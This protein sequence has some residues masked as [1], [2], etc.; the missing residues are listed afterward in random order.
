M[1]RLVHPP[2]TL[3]NRNRIT[4]KYRLKI[5]HGNIDTDPF[6]PDEDDEKSRSSLA[7]AGVDQEDANVS[8]SLPITA[9]HVTHKWSRVVAMCSAEHHLQAVLSEA[10]QRNYAPQQRPSRGANDKKAAPPA[11]YIPTPD[12]TGK[13]ENYE[14]LYP[15]NK[16]KDPVTYVCTSTTVEEAISYALAH[17]CTY[18]MDERDKEWLDKNNEE[19]RGEGTSVQGAVST[20]SGVRTSA[21]SAKAKGKEPESSTPVVIS[22]DEFELAMGLFEKV[23]HEKTEHLHL[24]LGG[25][26]FPSFADYQDTFS[27]PLVPSDFAAFAVPSW[28]PPPSTLLRIGRAVYPHWK[29]RR[30]EREGHR[31]IPTLNGDESD[32]LN[33]SYICFRRR[34]IKA[35]RKTRASQVTS[36]DKLL[37]LQGEFAY[38][39]D[40]A[41][42]V[43]AR[44]GLKQ[45]SARQAQN[46]W[47][48]RMAVVDLKRKF[49]S[50]GDRTD[51]ELLIDKERP[52]KK[53]EMSR[54][55]GLKIRTPNDPS[56]AMASARVEPA[57]KPQAR[58]AMIQSKIDIELTRQ[59]DH[60]WEDGIN[61]TYQQPVVPYASRLFKYVPP[62]G[63]PSWPSSASS[64][65]DDE[66]VV[67]RAVRVRVGRGGRIMLDRR[68]ATTTSVSI[69]KQSR[70]SLFGPPPDD[71]GNDE[72][73]VEDMN[74]LKERWRFDSDDY[75]AVG[76]DGPEEQDR[77]LTDEY[78]PKYL[79]H[80]MCLLSENDHQGLTTDTSLLFSSTDGSRDPTKVPGFRLGMQFIMTRRDA[81]GQPRPFPP[82]G[83]PPMISQQP[84]GPTA[85]LA[86]VNGTPISTQMKKMQPMPPAAGQH[87][88]RISSNGGMRPPN[89][90]VVASMQSHTSPPR[91][92]PPHPPLQQHSPTPPGSNG[93]INMPHL[94]QSNPEAAGAHGL[95]VANGIVSGHQPSEPT[96]LLQP[97]ENMSNGVM[98][99]NSPV[100]PKSVNQHAPGTN[101][102]QMPNM[103]GGMNGYLPSGLPSNAAYLPPSSSSLSVQQKQLLQAA[104]SNPP[105][106]LQDLQGMQPNGGN[107]QMPG[108][109]GYMLPNGAMF[110]MALGTGTNIN[111][112]LPPARQMNW[113]SPMR[114]NSAMNGMEGAAMN[115]GMNGGMNG[116]MN[117]AM[118]GSSL[119]GA[120]NGPLINGAI[121]SMNGS[122]NGAMNGS[123][124]PSPNH[125]HAVP[126][127]VRTPSANGSRNGIRA[128]NGQ[129]NG[130]L[131]S[132]SMSPH[133]QHSPS[134]MPSISQSQSP[135]RPPMTPMQMGEHNV[136]PRVFDEALYVM[137]HLPLLPGYGPGSN[138]RSSLPAKTITG[139]SIL[140]RLS[141][142]EEDGYQGSYFPAAHSPKDRHDGYIS[143][144]SPVFARKSYPGHEGPFSHESVPET[145]AS[146][147][148]ETPVSEPEPLP[149]EP[150]TPTNPQP[151]APTPEEEVAEVIFFEYGVVVFF[152]LDEQQEKS[153]LEDVENAGIM[154]KKIS[155]EDWEIEECHFA[156]DRHIAYPR[157]YNDFF[158]LKSRSHLL[159]LSIAHALAQSTLLAHYETNTQRV[160]SS[161]LTLS[162][163]KQL[164]TSGALQLRRHDAL[165]LTGSLFKLRRDVNLVSNVLDVPELFWSEASLK[166]LYDAVREYMEIKGRVQV[167]NEKLA[168][169]SDFLDAIHDHLNNFA[170]ERIT[171]IIIWQVL[172]RMGSWRVLTHPLRL[173]VAAILVELGEVV[174][175]LIVHATMGGD[176][177]D[178]VLS[179]ESVLMTLERMML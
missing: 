90:P 169:A 119:T 153:I 67:Q 45:E 58:A 81:S 71:D 108:P 41:K 30:V 8:L 5:I 91:A 4:N 144:E 16:W 92:S 70:S 63:A 2:T 77:V 115:G 28:I 43:L 14:Q 37:R 46:V 25:M 82:G 39:L 163:P 6:I 145:P 47:E 54:L 40:L 106:Q 20:A 117:G 142:A 152:G 135:P 125:R 62:S 103:N 44:E 116:A 98:R 51:D 175:R 56:T 165:K 151:A 13:V 150:P 146:E 15:S 121:G 147:V 68:R 156:H 127:P 84:N 102:Y 168:V 172:S 104:F 132:H 1:P 19:A 49:P 76:P 139:K 161:P 110:N 160:L 60:H 138:I 130:Q 136:A 124:S 157:I 171:W 177:A 86:P 173:I 114:P 10:A 38:P 85:P 29:E 167:L 89:V 105:N 140:S 55:P 17:E 170:M 122:M 123:M 158:T 34:E 80:S 75:P 27:S 64:T 69:V 134:P 79:R 88:P 100:R 131:N 109:G 129:M 137:Y 24:S 154:K 36:S 32:V 149:G 112:K 78:D 113:A 74:R 52:P 35:V 3:R 164:A 176:S 99:A 61:N 94:G 48:K 118:N 31:I 178:P 12:S 107:R 26:P 95:P 18:Y 155:E 141:E 9:G 126:V 11:A 83:Q 96:N 22:E 133:M 179:R 111:L 101:G 23:T 159:K 50:L 162:I 97:P 73:D 59:K 42:A 57:M 93:Q 143:S 7:V 33:E 65:S 21:R 128:M 120:M 174:A 166:E 66:P 87:L 148:P 72:M 53:Q